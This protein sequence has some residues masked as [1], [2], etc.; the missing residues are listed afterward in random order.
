MAHRTL[1]EAMRMVLEDCPNRTATTEQITKEVIGR[2]LYF[3]KN[4][5]DVFPDQIFLRARKYPQLFELTGRT[6]VKLR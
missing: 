2:K 3:Q 4:G 6:I 1:H 5:G